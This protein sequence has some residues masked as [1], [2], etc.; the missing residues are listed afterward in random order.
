MIATIYETNS[1]QLVKSS[2]TLTWLQRREQELL[3]SQV[4]DVPIPAPS[5]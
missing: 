3:G 2:A 1:E 4:L 5:L